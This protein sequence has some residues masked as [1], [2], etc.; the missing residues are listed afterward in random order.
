M[1]QCPPGSRLVPGGGGHMCQCPDNT[2]ANVDGCAPTFSNPRQ[3]PKYPI[4]PIK[5]TTPSKIMEELVKLGKF[6]NHGEQLY[7]PAAGSLSGQLP[8]GTIEI[9]LI[10]NPYVDPFTGRAVQLQPQPRDSS[11]VKPSPGQPGSYAACAGASTFG[12]PNAPFCEMGGYIYFRNGNV[13]KK[14]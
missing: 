8:Q 3:L 11:S 13:L 12:G 4:E 9:P 5:P 10:G 6:V 1:Y 2:F 14:D 7:N